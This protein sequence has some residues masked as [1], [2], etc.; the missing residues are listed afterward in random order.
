VDG[1][2]GKSD[3]EST[4]DRGERRM[5][6]NDAPGTEDYICGFSRVFRPSRTTRPRRLRTRRAPALRLPRRLQHAHSRCEPITSPDVSKCSATFCTR[7]EVST[8][9]CGWIGGC[10]GIEGKDQRKKT[11]LA[12]EFMLVV[13]VCEHSAVGQATKAQRVDI[14][15][16]RA[17]YSF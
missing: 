17:L 14:C 10:V 3:K 5:G 13:S 4:E 2:D 16:L 6:R 11:Y 15:P 8:C 7:V 9:G 1:D 12:L